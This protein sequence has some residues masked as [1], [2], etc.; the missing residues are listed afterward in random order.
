MGPRPTC[1][2]TNN[3]GPTTGRTRR[4]PELGDFLFRSPLDVAAYAELEPLV[5]W[6]T[7]PDVW[8]LDES[9]A[10]RCGSKASSCQTVRT[11]AKRPGA[12]LRCRETELG[13]RCPDRW[14]V[15]EPRHE[16]LGDRYRVNEG[17]AQAFLALR[18]GLARHGI[19]LLD[20]MVRASEAKPGTPIWAG[21]V[22]DSETIP[23]QF[24]I[25]FPFPG[26]WCTQGEYGRSSGRHEK[27]PSR[28]APRP[29][30][31]PYEPGETGW[32]CPSPRRRT[33]MACAIGRQLDRQPT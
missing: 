23:A 32:R 28:Y 29:R 2:P 3:V 5:T 1:T 16:W 9:G 25:R 10:F 26:S 15:T 22:S 6:R 11:L 33:A 30:R 27:C 18:R 19:T 21:I 14:V 24:E 31:A 12:M 8:H 13:Y 17:D 20:V 7:Y 4:N